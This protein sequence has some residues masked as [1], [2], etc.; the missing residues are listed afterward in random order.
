LKKKPPPESPRDELN[1]LLRENRHRIQVING[2][3]TELKKKK[4]P[5]GPDYAMKQA[6]KQKDE[7]DKVSQ[8][9]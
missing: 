3:Q 8:K 1:E 7:L 9:N 6:K 4:A 5:K 2:K